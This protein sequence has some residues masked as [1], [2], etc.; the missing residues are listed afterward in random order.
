MPEMQPGRQRDRAQTS[1]LIG[2]PINRRFFGVMSEGMVCVR[3]RYP[4]ASRRVAR[5]TSIAIAPSSQPASAPA[6]SLV[7]DRDSRGAPRPSRGL[8]PRHRGRRR[9]AHRTRGSRPTHRWTSAGIRGCR[10][11]HTAHAPADAAIPRQSRHARQ[12]HCAGPSDRR[13]APRARSRRAAAWRGPAIR[14]RP[15]RQRRGRRGTS[16]GRDAP[17]PTLRITP[18]AEAFP[19]RRQRAP[20]CRTTWCPRTGRGRATVSLSRA[21]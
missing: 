19:R 20:V 17:P 21:P 15:R 2:A 14:G 12:W 9:S 7:R 6:S 8:T 4:F 16:V 13:R 10:R 18:C 11:G 1:Q 5:S 3:T